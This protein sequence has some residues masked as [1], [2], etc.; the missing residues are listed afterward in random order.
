MKIDWHIIATTFP[1]RTK[2]RQYLWSVE[3][4]AH[5]ADEVEVYDVWR[6]AIL[7]KLKKGDVIG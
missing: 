4:V 7:P 6:K 5:Q 3:P 2:A 1:G